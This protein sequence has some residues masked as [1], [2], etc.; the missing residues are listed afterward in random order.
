MKFA[1]LFG[2]FCVLNLPTHTIAADRIGMVT[3]TQGKVIVL[4]GQKRLLLNEQMQLQEGDTLKTS[5][6]SKVQLK[7]RDDTVIT[8]ANR[9]QFKLSQY[10][11]NKA[12]ATSNVHLE[13]V[14]GAFRAVTGAIGKQRS[15]K[16]EVKTKVARPDVRP[17]LAGL[18]SG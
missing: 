8:L 4:R 13:L 2:L 1:L 16:F 15:P 17:A 12:K 18:F 3:K 6:N 9:T 7:L 11:Y 10:Q 14:E 5:S